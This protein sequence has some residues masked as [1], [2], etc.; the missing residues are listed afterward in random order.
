MQQDFLQRDF[1]GGF[2]L[3]MDKSKLGESEFFGL[4]NGRSRFSNIQPILCP[5]QPDG[6]P[7]GKYQGVYA[8]DRY[9]IVF[10]SGNAYFK[11]FT[12]ASAG[13]VQIEGFSMD[14]TV[15]YIY[16][17]LV[18]VSSNNY[19]R[20][21]LGN[22]EDGVSFGS[23]VVGSPQV[24]VVQDGI[25]QPWLILPDGSS[26][27]AFSYSEWTTSLRE[28]VP[29]GKQMTYSSGRLYIVATDG[30]TI[31]RSVTGRPLDFVVA[32]DTN[33]DQIADTEEGGGATKTHFSVDFNS[34]THISA[35]N[36]GDGALLVTT[37]KNSYMVTVNYQ[38][39]IY[40]E[41]G[42]NV[43]PLFSTGA[44][45]QFS[46]V[47]I[48]GDQALV[49]FAGIRSFN[50]AMQLNNEGRNAPFSSRIFKLF[51]GVVQLD[52]AAVTF[53][54]Y[55]L[56]A[57]DTIYGPAVLVYDTLR[58][59]YN[60]IDIYEGVGSIKMFA[61]VKVLGSRSLLFITDSGLYEAFT[62]PEYETLTMVTRAF[63]SGNMTYA[64]KAE[65]VDLDFADVNE[66]VTASLRVFTDNAPGSSRTFALQPGV[67]GDGED[68]PLPFTQ[69]DNIRSVTVKT[70]SEKAGAQT[71]LY[72]SW[73]GN[74]QLQ[75]LRLRASLKSL[76]NRSLSSS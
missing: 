4:I 75:S 22:P 19:T 55:A 51:E 15:D 39:A 70:P 58:Q 72:L 13:F 37:A 71:A 44:I 3:D 56:F 52:P 48:L 1:S 74:A 10:V 68:I 27:K 6:L 76:T 18:P 25:N 26:R 30:R 29:I 20:T 67:Q 57:V 43:T 59:V 9:A 2:R 66:L 23:A 61:E 42:F 46:V 31:Y 45:N 8:A 69:S 33:A 21:S 65:Y 49:G 38:T 34:I 47:D 50:A 53:D 63:T 35:A 40:A 12:N 60:G 64:L 17:T 5:S 54:D 7:A 41:P 62:G 73:K 28:Y 16:A 14:A 24:V 32:V 11:D 36:A